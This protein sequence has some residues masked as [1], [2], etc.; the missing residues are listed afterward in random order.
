MKEAT[1][2][3][4]SKPKAKKKPITKPITTT[5]TKKPLPVV[6]STIKKKVIIPVKPK[7]TPIPISKDKL[8]TQAD[9]VRTILR[10][11]FEKYILT[12]T[13]F[14]TKGNT[15]Y[16]KTDTGKTYRLTYKTTI[17]NDKKP[18]K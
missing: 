9:M 16:T 14:N 8:L 5:N 1:M 15:I 10:D 3:I 13:K 2:S 7:S 11:T 17:V 18:N 6:K 4:T 12:F